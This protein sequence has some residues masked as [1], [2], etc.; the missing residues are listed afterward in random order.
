M[1]GATHACVFVCPVCACT[2]VGQTREDGG[3][4]PVHTVLDVSDQ[5]TSHNIFQP[6]SVLILNVDSVSI[7]YKHTTVFLDRCQVDEKQDEVDVLL[8]NGRRCLVHKSGSYVF[9]VCCC[10][11]AALF[12][13]TFRPCSSAFSKPPLGLKAY[14]TNCRRDKL[15][16][17]T[18]LVSTFLTYC[19][20]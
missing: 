7:V 5:P 16:K 3:D 14:L 18:N 1:A 8:E 4:D 15:T 12:S 9:L 2:D 6:S 20:T 19:K 11:Y 13:S 10:A 17:F